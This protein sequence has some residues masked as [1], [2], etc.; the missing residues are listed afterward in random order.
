M[1]QNYKAS[2]NDSKLKEGEMLGTKIN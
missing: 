1:K 2:E